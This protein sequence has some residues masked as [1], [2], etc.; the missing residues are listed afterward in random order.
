[1][2]YVLK[3][4]LC[5]C[6]CVCA[7]APAAVCAFADSPVAVVVLDRTGG[8]VDKDFS[9]LWTEMVRRRFHFP[10]YK[11]IGRQE[12]LRVLRGQLPPPGRKPPYY[13]AEDLKLIAGRASADLLFVIIADRLDEALIH[14]RWPFGETLLRV[15]VSIDLMAYRVADAKHLEK[16]IR[17]FKTDVL[18]TAL[19]AEKVANEQVGDAID[20]FRAKLPT[21]IIAQGDADNG[22]Q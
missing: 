14:S 4:F 6:L 22:G 3:A 15:S 18:G 2:K 1:M 19:S 20:E 7:F 13:R 8:V 16:K 21:L 5:V 12:L 17:Y 10:D 11:L 9:E